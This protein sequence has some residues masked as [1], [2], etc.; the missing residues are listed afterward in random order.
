MK[1]LPTDE[2]DVRDLCSLVLRGLAGNQDLLLDLIMQ[3]R[4]TRCCFLNGSTC[5]CLIPVGGLW[6]DGY[7]RTAHCIFGIAPQR[8]A[9]AERL[10][11][12]CLQPTDASKKSLS[13]PALSNNDG[14]MRA[15]SRGPVTP[16]FVLD[17]FCST[18]SVNQVHGRAES[19]SRRRHPHR[20]SAHQ[21][22]RNVTGF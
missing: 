11:G 20:R 5:L 10:F 4:S 14:H 17:A 15:R 21:A 16:G 2:D 13:P 7:T 19:A 1:L 22:R 12:A 6:D 3:P 9:G 8:L 18:F